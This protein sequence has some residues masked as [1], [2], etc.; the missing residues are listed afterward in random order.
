MIVF[1]PAAIR[2]IV[3]NPPAPPVCVAPYRLPAASIA[4]PP[5]GPAP[6]VPLN[7]AIVVIV[8][9]PTSILNTTPDV[10]IPPWLAPP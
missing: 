5:I 8:L 1:V 9:V 4:T 3:P 10:L 6:F 2:Y 7:R